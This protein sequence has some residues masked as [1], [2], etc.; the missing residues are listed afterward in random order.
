[1]IEHKG[2]HR[3]F[4]VNGEPLQREEDVHIMF[5]L[6]WLGTATDVSREA[7]D[8]RGPAD[9]KISKGSEDKTIVEFKLAKN[10]Q[11]K[12]NLEKQTEIYKKASGAKDG[13]KVILYFT[14][15]E[16]QKVQSILADLKLSGS[17]D[18]IVIDARN[19]NKP[20]GSKA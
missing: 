16:L 13:L 6:T 10:P 2:G 8:G 7:N 5:R 3:L 14:E 20:S 18:V 1:V 4:Y 15:A 12:R 19:D 17:E 9:F 11:L